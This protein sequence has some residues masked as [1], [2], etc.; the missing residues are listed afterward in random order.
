MSGKFDDVIEQIR[1]VRTK[2][3]CRHVGARLVEPC[4]DC[5]GEEMDPETGFEG[6]GMNLGDAVLSS[7]LS[8]SSLDL[9]DTKLHET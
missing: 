6:P 2:K 1:G 7:C 8:L 9:S 5:S 3:W 4:V